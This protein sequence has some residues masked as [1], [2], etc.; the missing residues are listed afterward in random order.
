MPLRYRVLLALLGALLVAGGVLGIW[1]GAR[2]A[3]GS[4]LRGIV[5]GVIAAVF[6]ARIIIYAYTN[7]LPPWLAAV[8]GDP[9]DP[10]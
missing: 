5:G 2:L 3:G 10:Q 4:Q 9:T 8:F 6:G 7:R 1:S